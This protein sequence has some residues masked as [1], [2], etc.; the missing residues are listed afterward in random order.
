LSKN[1]ARMDWSQEV[2]GH[3]NGFAWAVLLPEPAF[4][5]GFVKAKNLCVEYMFMDEVLERKFANGRSL[6]M[7]DVYPTLQLGGIP[8]ADCPQ[9]VKDCLQDQAKKYR[10]VGWGKDTFS[11]EIVGDLNRGDFSAFKGLFETISKIV[12]I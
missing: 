9:E 11:K 6:E 5:A 1:F 4:R 8:Q 3:K 2:K 12:E 7:K 10:K